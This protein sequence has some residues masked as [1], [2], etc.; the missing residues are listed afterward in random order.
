MGGSGAVGEH[1]PDQRAGDREAQQWGCGWWQWQVEWL[2]QLDSG[3]GNLTVA[4]AG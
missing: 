3:S 1:G 2:W 4:V